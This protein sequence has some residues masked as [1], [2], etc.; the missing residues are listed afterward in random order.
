V[1]R[2]LT[3]SG[4]AQRELSLMLDTRELY[5]SPNGD[6]W[7]LVREVSSGRVFIRHE[8]NK[9]SGGRAAD[10]EIGEFL[11]EGRR[12][13]EHVELLR[14]IGSLAAADQATEEGAD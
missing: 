12:G 3:D 11:I 14:L 6:K 2:L 1:L 5:L 4:A 7:L 8:P 13:P 10:I 9:P